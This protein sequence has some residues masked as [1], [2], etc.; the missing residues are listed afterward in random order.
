MDETHSFFYTISVIAKKVNSFLRNEMG[1]FTSVLAYAFIFFNAP[2]VAQNSID[3]SGIGKSTGIL[4]NVFTEA[5]GDLVESKL[6]QEAILRFAL[7]QLPHTENE[8]DKYKTSLKNEIIKK[9]GA[10]VHQDLP[11]NLI[12]TGSLR[13]KGY[14]VKNIAFQ[15]RPGIYA[16][17]NL[18]VP[19]GDGKFP[20]VIVMMG[21][22]LEGR[23]Y[24]KY[25][26]VGITLAL[27]GYVSLCIDP[28]G[29]G[30]RTTIHGVFEDHG[31]ENNLG[32]ALMD[33][34]E[35]L[36]GM[37]ITDNIRGVDFLC[38]LPY[39][40]TSKIG[41]TGASGG[42]NQTMWLSAMDERIKAAVPV[43]SAGTFEAYIMRTPCIC[44]VLVDGLTFTEESAVLALVAP[45]AIKM[46]NHF[47]DDLA[48][49]HPR[50]MLRS[51]NDA[52]PVFELAGAG[53]NIAYQTFDLTHGY[54][55][56][57]RETMLG[58][59]NLYLKGIG[60]GNPVKEISFNTLPI[61]QLMVY[62][63]GKRDPRVVT[64][65]EYCKQRGNEL[66]KVFLHTNSFDT[67]AKRNELRKIL[68]VNEEPVLKK[69]HEYTQA[70]GWRRFAL[71][72]DDKLIPVVVYAPKN[73]KQFV[74]LSNMDEKENISANLI[75]S[76]IKKGS[77]LAVVDLSGTGETSS[78]ALCS[79]DSIG[80]LRTLTKSSLWLGKTLM[81]EWVKELEVVTQFIRKEYKETKLSLIGNKEAGLAVLFLA[82][83]KQ[84]IEDVTLQSAPVSY[85]FDNRKSVE[86]FSTA[87]HLPGLL[88]WGDVSLVAALSGRNVTF[89]NP[90][91][92]SGQK[93]GD[94]KLREYK[95]EFDH[96]RKTCGKDSN[97][98]FQ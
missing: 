89:I 77:G 13:M 25:Q 74:I 95:A 20:A 82:A 15:T 12:E 31:D 46:C 64:T 49:F 80:R 42:G 28:W 17:A 26:A 38:S 52:K 50:E 8:W 9:T 73:S 2:A 1:K 61:D 21:H 11:L 88:S 94:D 39:V 75:D 69:V 5:H 23:L 24:D 79:N 47:K 41:A 45:R 60:N 37:L 51:Y 36:I 6:R 68:R 16:T 78:V 87:I 65:E 98:T 32:F 27:N 34:G 48:A 3:T 62:A 92:M 18:Y 44:E 4:P 57:D 10:L 85:L 90:V 33:I 71:E 40:D 19:D 63:K 84:N 43:V 59:F 53:N 67:T 7:L 70:N 81:G 97:T 83:L 35:S 29:S 91:S 14:T 56:E 86:Y 93:L 58:W 72:T 76:V 96:V 22:S 54:W 30:E 66:K 55:P